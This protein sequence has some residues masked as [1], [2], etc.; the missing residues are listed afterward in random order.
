MRD[1]R[2]LTNRG[3]SPSP[4]RQ[5]EANLSVPG[6]SIVFP[7]HPDDPRLDQ[8]PVWGLPGFLSAQ[9]DEPSWRL[10]TTFAVIS[11]SPK[12]PP[13]KPGVGM[14]PAQ[15][16]PNPHR[17][18]ENPKALDMF[19]PATTVAEKGRRWWRECSA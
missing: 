4:Y 9:E 19:F 18:R 3:F 14:P 8:D 7:F 16:T 1:I 17:T 6:I 15:R 12:G 13:P 2:V 10:L 5:P 11:A